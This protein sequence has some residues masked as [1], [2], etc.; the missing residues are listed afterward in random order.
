MITPPFHLH[1]NFLFKEGLNIYKQIFMQ[2]SERNH[3]CWNSL[4]NPEIGIANLIYIKIRRLS[5]N[6]R[7]TF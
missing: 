1:P 6:I 7:S 2:P 5:N 4:A 3:I